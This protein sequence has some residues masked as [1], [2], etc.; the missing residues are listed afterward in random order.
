MRPAVDVAIDLARAGAHSRLIARRGYVKFASGVHNEKRS[1]S[2]RS[3]TRVRAR[4]RMALADLLRR[5]RRV[6]AAPA[7]A[8]GEIVRRHLGPSSPWYL[9]DEFQ[10]LVEVR[11][12][13]RLGAVKE[14]ESG[15]IRLELVGDEADI[16]DVVETDNVICATGYRADLGRLTMLDDALRAPH[17]HPQRLARRSTRG[18]SRACPACSSSGTPRRCRSDR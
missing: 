2:R 14:E 3:S 12:G 5:A 11:T 9:R 17:P 10:E 18:S 13:T 16:P 4:S 15:P 8:R 1:L 7:K 6:P